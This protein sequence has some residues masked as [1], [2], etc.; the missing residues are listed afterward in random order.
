[1]SPRARRILL[2]LALVLAA[3]LVVAVGVVLELKRRRDRPRV[4]ARE[5]GAVLE[6]LPTPDGCSLVAE[7]LGDVPPAHIHLLDL[8]GDTPSRDL[9]EEIGGSLR[10]AHA[11]RELALVSGRPALGAPSVGG[12]AV[13]DLRSLGRTPE[14]LCAFSS[15]GRLVLTNVSEWAYA[16]VVDVTTGKKC[17]AYDS[18]WGAKTAAFSPDGSRF[19]VGFELEPTEW[20]VVVAETASGNRFSVFTPY[21]MPRSVLFPDREHVIVVEDH[22]LELWDASTGKV[23]EQSYW[24][25]ASSTGAD[26]SHDRRFVAV[27]HGEGLTLRIHDT[28]TLEPLVVRRLSDEMIDLRATEESL[29]CVAFSPEDDAVFV[30]TTRGLVVRVPVRLPGRP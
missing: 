4:V 14:P 7:V 22:A 10:L 16:E 8:E 13:R 30:G 11:P 26:L 6:L 29:R 2:A 1:V 19:A 23:V 5:R 9:E 3:G 25:R 24:K 27:V 28:R 21:E 20:A 18:L 15:D 12:L 17:G